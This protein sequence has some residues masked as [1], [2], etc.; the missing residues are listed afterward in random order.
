MKSNTYIFDAKTIGVP[1]LIVFLMWFVFWVEMRFHT[2]FTKYGLEPQTVSGLLG[3]L[4]SPFIHSG[5]SH[6]WSNTIPMLILSVSLM[7]FYRF[8]SIKVLIYGILL[9]GVLTWGIGRNSFHIGASG[10][11]YMLASFLFFKGIFTKYYKLIALSFT[12]VFLYG[13]L[14]W[15]LFPV[16][17]NI[18]WEGHSSGAMAGLILAILMKSKVVPE[19]KYN[20][21]QPEYN[22]TEDL[23]MQQFDEE[24]NFSPLKPDEEE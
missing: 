2:D 5:F 23:F 1:L 16:D 14:V 22:A 8:I 19:K 3:I 13:S 18:S 7:Y 17:P 21:Q 9:T 12:V 20:W 10:L 15:Y 11:V 6:L 4:T 24:G